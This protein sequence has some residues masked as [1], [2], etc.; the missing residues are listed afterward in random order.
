MSIKTTIK[1]TRQEAIDRLNLIKNWIINYQYIDIDQNSNENSYRDDLM[2]FVDF[3]NERFSNT[4]KKY[5]FEN[6]S[7]R[8]LE[9]F[10]SSPYYRFTPDENYSVSDY[11]E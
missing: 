11:Y 6:Y 8:M 4:P 10:M 9:D 3:Y 1:I 7:N 2:K 5:M